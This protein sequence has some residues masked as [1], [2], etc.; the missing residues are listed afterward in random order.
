MNNLDELLSEVKNEINNEECVKEYFRLKEIISKDQEIKTLTKE[1]QVHQKRM[2][3]YQNDDDIYFNE[4]ALYED[5][6]KKLE[7]NPIYQNFINVKVEVNDL[8]KEVAN[9]LQ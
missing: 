6:L 9:Y 2:C 7:S 8:L 5:N 3:E 4:K 1:I